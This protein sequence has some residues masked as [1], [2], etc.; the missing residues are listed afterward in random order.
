[1]N[2]ITIAAAVFLSLAFS[3]N[4]YRGD[5]L[6]QA[7][8][9]AFYNYEFDKSVSIL[10]KARV[11]YPDHPGVHLIWAA[12]RWV[13]SQ[14]HNSTDESYATL[15]NDLL[16]IQPKYEQLISKYKYDPNYKLYQ[17]SAIGLTARVS[18]GKKQW[19]KT[20]YRSYKGFSIIED[21][22]NNSPEIIDA[23]LPI[24]IVNYFG[25]INNVFLKWTVKM[26]GL[27]AS[28][29]IGLEKIAIAAES[30][31]WSWIEAKAILC[32]LYL[33]VENEPL[34]AL[35]HAKDLAEQ[36]PNNYYFKLLYCE[37]LIRNNNLRESKKILIQ[38][39]D[40]IITLTEKQKEWYIPYQNY[41][42]ALLNFYQG[43]YD[44]TLDLVKKTIKEYTGELDIILGNAYLLEGMANDKLDRRNKARE[45]YNNCIK[46][47]NFSMAVELSKKYLEQP[48]TKD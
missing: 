28:K 13:Q 5:S 18:L 23:Q 47:E 1:M 3:S 42:M 10:D 26:Y 14:A 9:Y 41:E 43:N 33:W 45:S 39:D 16:E 48:Y 6:I 27:E 40:M 30:G 31:Q 20:L 7:G 25:G 37:S 44:K 36:F 34:L 21:V 32:N 24:G 35:E 38:M 15:E 17:G 12:S 4:Y 46:L 8:V 19:F 2:R 22:A 11:E 29:E